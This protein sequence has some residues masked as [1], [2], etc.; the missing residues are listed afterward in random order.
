MALLRYDGRRGLETLL[1]LTI[2]YFVAR[3]KTRSVWLRASPLLTVE[4]S[5]FRLNLSHKADADQTRRDVG[6]WPILLKKAAVA[7]Q[8][9]Q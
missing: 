9:Y 2:V 4:C 3:S 6:S 8:R 1:Y 5:G 7:T